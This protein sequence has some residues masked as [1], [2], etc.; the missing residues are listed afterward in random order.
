MLFLSDLIPNCDHVLSWRYLISVL[1]RQFYNLFRRGQYLPSYLFCIHSWHFCNK[2]ELK[3]HTSSFNIWL[4][5][6]GILYSGMKV[7]ETVDSLFLKQ[8]SWRVHSSEGLTG[9]NTNNLGKAGKACLVMSSLHPVFS[10][11]SLLISSWFRE[12]NLTW[13]FYDLLK[14]MFK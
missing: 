10:Q 9:C 8:A 12:K 6:H 14:G 7:N 2:R 1:L 3:N 4:K 5:Y 11:S 13:S